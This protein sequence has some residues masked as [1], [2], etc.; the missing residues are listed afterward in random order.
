MLDSKSK[1]Q[2]KT[3]DP[4]YVV[5]ACFLLLEFLVVVTLNGLSNGTPGLFLNST[6]DISDLYYVDI[7]PAGWAFSI[8]GLIYVW[9]ALWI[10]YVVFN[11]CR[12]NNYGKVYLNPATVTPL[13]LIVYMINLVLNVA[14][15]F[16]WDRQ[17]VPVAFAILALTAFTL[18]V[19]LWLNH[20]AVRQNIVQMRNHHRVDL[21]LNRL[22]IQ[23]GL[24]IYATW[25][26]IATL[27]NFSMTLQYFANVDPKTACLVALSILT[28][29]LVLYVIL[30][31]FIWDAYLRSTFMPYLVVIWA[32]S[33]AM[34]NN[35]DSESAVSVFTAVIVGLA[36]A[37]LVFKILMVIVRAC[38]ERNG[39]AGNGDGSKMAKVVA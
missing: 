4:L 6:G 9:Q 7:V 17:H 28:V 32:T 3:S 18:Y 10:I 33:S 2:R 34:V 30:D 22:L 21:W 23:N 29:E 13:F 36:C 27:L 24:A 14:W 5:L 19:C 8:W 1:M 37:A 25:C 38:R 11:I 39:G 15:L 31:N 16:T 12:S 20:R 26:S 35:W